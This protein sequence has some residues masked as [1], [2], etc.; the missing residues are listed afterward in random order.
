MSRL[1]LPQRLLPYCPHR[2]SMKEVNKQILNFV[3]N[4]N[5]SYF[6]CIPN[7]VKTAVRHQRLKRFQ[8]ECL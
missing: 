2:M 7:N 3:Q 4:K 5:I 8:S 6:V 1:Q